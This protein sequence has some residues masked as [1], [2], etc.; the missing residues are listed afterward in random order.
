MVVN[1]KV[2]LTKRPEGK[3]S[4]SDFR[5]VEENIGE[6]GE[7]EVLLQVEYLS[8]DEDYFLKIVNEHRNP[9]VWEASGNDFKLKYPLF[10]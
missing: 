9:E 4:E 6:I 3:L 10:I 8:I 7:G 2:V 1:R 5:V